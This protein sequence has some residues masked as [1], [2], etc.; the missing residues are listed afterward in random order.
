[1]KKSKIVAFQSDE[2]TRKRL[3][4]FKKKRKKSKTEARSK[5]L[6]L[7]TTLLTK[8]DARED[9]PEFVEG[10]L[11]VQFEHNFTR[12]TEEVRKE[13]WEEIWMRGL[14]DNRV[15]HAATHAYTPIIANGNG[16]EPS[17]SAEET[18]TSKSRAR[19]ASQ[20]QEESSSSPDTGAVDKAIGSALK[21]PKDVATRPEKNKT[22][23]QK[24]KNPRKRARPSVE[25]ETTD[26]SRDKASPPRKQTQETHTKH[27]QLQAANNSVDD[28]CREEKTVEN[29]MEPNT[30]TEE[31]RVAS[32][33]YG[34]TPKVLKAP[35]RSATNLPLYTPPYARVLLR[36]KP[37]N[38]Q[39]TARSSHARATQARQ[40]VKKGKVLVD[41]SCA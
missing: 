5:N 29:V 39:H 18:G 13:M 37:R 23:T 28:K 6:A 20:N 41:S 40:R 33:K 19:D 24:P 32:R 9:F 27:L 4:K 15:N 17:K 21:K 30:G 35:K 2:E 36:V 34:K 38:E 12:P 16:I 14:A 10:T 11:P 8:C 7:S 25:D 31:L 26:T 22:T 1:M 3:K